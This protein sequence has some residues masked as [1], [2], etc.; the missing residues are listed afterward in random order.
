M[1]LNKMA[2]EA[3]KRV[4]QYVARAAAQHKRQMLEKFRKEKQ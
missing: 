4:Q 1:D 3:A 2:A